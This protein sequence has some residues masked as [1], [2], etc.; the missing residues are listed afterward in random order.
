MSAIVANFRFSIHFRVASGLEFVQ[1]VHFARLEASVKEFK[2]EKFVPQNFARQK[3]GPDVAK[4]LLFQLKTVMQL[5]KGN[6][7]RVGVELF[8]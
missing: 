2:H 1:A 6:H 7:S 3:T 4:G 8:Q 5:G